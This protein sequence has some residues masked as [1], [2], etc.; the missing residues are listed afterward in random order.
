MGVDQYRAFDSWREPERIL[1]EARLAVMD[2]SGESARTVHPEVVA[3]HGDPSRVVFV[4]VERVDV[5]STE[6]RRAFRSGAP[7]SDLVPVG[8]AEVV[9]ARGLYAD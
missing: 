5:S 7:V 8:V 9:E 2:R 3:R 6:V 4:P 1:E